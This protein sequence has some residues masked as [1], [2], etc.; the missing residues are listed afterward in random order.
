MLVSNDLSRDIIQEPADGHFDDSGEDT[1]AEGG[2]SC[3]CFDLLLIEMKGN[4]LV[5]I[6]AAV[7]IEIY[8]LIRHREKRTPPHLISRS[9]QLISS[10]KTDTTS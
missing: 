4:P 2:D 3:V 1:I 6:I 5:L 10:H 8:S 7:R 9:S